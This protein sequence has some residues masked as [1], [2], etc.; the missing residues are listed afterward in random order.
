[1]SDQV[2]YCQL[3]KDYAYWTEKRR[4]GQRNG[5]HVSGLLT[6]L[7]AGQVKQNILFDVGLG[8]LEAIA[9]FCPDS[10]WDEPL[11]IFITHGHIDHH[12]EL[13]ILS[14]IYCLRRGTHIH[15]IRPPLQIFCTADTHKHL[16]RTHWYGYNG[17]NTLQHLLIS[18]EK[19]IHLGPFNITPLAVDHFE[20]AVIYTIEFTLEKQHKIIVGWDM[21]TLPLKKI[22]QLQ[23]PSLALVEATTWQAVEGVND[24]TCLEDLAKTGFLEKLGQGYHPEQ[25]KYGVYLVHYSGLE[26]P[27][28]MLTDRQLKAKIDD[29]FPSLSNIVRVAERGQQWQFT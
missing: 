28:G 4:V 16:S 17:G 27:W 23:H 20:G 21:T 3:N 12:A 25:G 24:H 26:D 19:P 2:V 15:D 14:E 1:M 8:T 9:D 13:M 6:H 11:S 18:P 5:G 10:F 7:Q 22:E 29:T